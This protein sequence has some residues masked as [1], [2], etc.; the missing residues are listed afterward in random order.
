VAAG[1]CEPNPWGFS[2]VDTSSFDPTRPGRS[3]HVNIANSA[4]LAGYHLTNILATPITPAPGQTIRSTW[5]IF[6]TQGKSGGGPLSVYIGA[7]MGGGGSYAGTDRGPQMAWWGD[8]RLTVFNGVPTVVVPQYPRDVW[9]SVRVDIHLDTQTWDFYWAPTG[10]PLQL[11]RSNLPWRSA[12]IRFPWMERW[13]VA[14]FDG[15][16]DFTSDCYMDNVTL[17]LACPADFNGSGGVNSQDFFDFLTAFF[18][19]APNAD[20]NHDGVINSQDL[21]DFL[22]AFFAG[23]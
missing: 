15:I 8:G 11:L 10:Q 23:C 2:I 6:V 22:T 17:D 14:H 7:D 12:G 20:F 1:L 4:S 16:G 21:F 5:E 18:A 3:L 19:A 9:Q 13:S